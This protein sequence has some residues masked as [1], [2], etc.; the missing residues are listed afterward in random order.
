MER[1]HHVSDY[2]AMVRNDFDLRAQYIMFAWR[3]LVHL[4]EEL[5]HVQSSIYLCNKHEIWKKGSVLWQDC[6]FS[7]DVYNV[8]PI[9][10]QI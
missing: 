6:F 1:P 9:D 5:L 7:D 3:L 10:S 2:V 8:R 4:A